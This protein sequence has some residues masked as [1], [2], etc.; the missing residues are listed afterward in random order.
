[1]T[2][3]TLPTHLCV[4]CGRKTRAVDPRCYDCRTDPADRELPAGRWVGTLVKRFVPDAPAPFVA[5]HMPARTLGALCNCGC[6]LTDATEP[7]PACLVWAIA[8]ANRASWA[9]VTEHYTP[10]ELEMA[11]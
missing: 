10:T 11:A 8:D 5:T 4:D 3:P 6:L 9:A 7:C 2:R 1:M